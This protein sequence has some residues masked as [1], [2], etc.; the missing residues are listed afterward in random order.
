MKIYYYRNE[1]FCPHFMDLALTMPAM[2][3][4]QCRSLFY[5]VHGFKQCS[6][7]V[8]TRKYVRSL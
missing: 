1:G 6:L 7:P 5:D 3:T 2:F 8:E 4:C